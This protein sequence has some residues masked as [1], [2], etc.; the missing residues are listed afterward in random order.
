MR[1]E[2]LKYECIIP[3]CKNSTKWEWALCNPCAFLS[4]EFVVKLYNKRPN[5]ELYNKMIQHAA[6]IRF[7]I[8]ASTTALEF[9][10]LD[11]AWIGRRHYLNKQEFITSRKWIKEP[12]KNNATS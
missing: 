10:N 6:C 8:S 7:G 2:K 11:F 3:F 1:V 4:G 5:A 12:E 9:K